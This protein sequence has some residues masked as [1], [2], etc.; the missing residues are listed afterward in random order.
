MNESFDRKPA[1]EQWGLILLVAVV[2]A[3]MLAL[4]LLLISPPLVSPL[5][6]YFYLSSRSFDLPGREGIELAL[7]PLGAAFGLL[8]R[9]RR[10]RVA[11]LASG[12]GRPASRYSAPS[13]WWPS[14]GIS[15]GRG[16]SRRLVNGRS[17]P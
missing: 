9:P 14:R 2:I 3:I 7:F 8:A 1:V 12:A 15:S 5:T 10:G 13:S 11:A 6:P 4:T 16:S 17:P